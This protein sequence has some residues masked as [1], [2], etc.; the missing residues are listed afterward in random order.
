MHSQ[1]PGNKFPGFFHPTNTP[2]TIHTVPILVIPGTV[3]PGDMGGRFTLANNP[4]DMLQAR[5]LVR[6]IAMNCGRKKFDPTK[7]ARCYMLFTN[8]VLWRQTYYEVLRF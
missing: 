5:S 4:R 3:F 7:A 8:T 1:S 6:K 2:A